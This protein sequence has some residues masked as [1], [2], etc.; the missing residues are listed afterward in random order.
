MQELGPEDAVLV[1][2]VQRD[3]C[4]GG[5]LAVPAGDEVVAPLNRWM[6]AAARGG[7]AIFASRD[8]HPPDHM[9]FRE[10]GGPWPPHCV[11][12]TEGAS[13]HP[14]L[15]LPP[16]AELLSK[17]QERDEEAYSAFDGTGLEARLRRRGIRRLYVGGLA[18][19]VCVRATVLGAL[20]RGFDAHVVVDATRAVEPDRA[21]A[22]LDELEAEGA[23]LERGAP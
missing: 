5:A 15:R 6:E 14:E 23:I 8:W 3:F 9:S 22:V 11:Q 13:L 21:E 20:S 16:G 18:R 2:D 10:R 7:A 17:G 1:V 4:A 19:D 12:G